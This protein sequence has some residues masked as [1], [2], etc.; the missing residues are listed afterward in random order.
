MV[1]DAH[2]DRPLAGTMWVVGVG[3][4]SNSYLYQ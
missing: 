3:K 2:A 1:D 4:A